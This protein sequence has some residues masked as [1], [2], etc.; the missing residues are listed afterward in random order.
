M[1]GRW[2][3][4]R[5]AARDDGDDLRAV[6]LDVEATGLDTRG[7]SLL[8]IAALALRVDWTTRRLSLVLGDSFS[9]RVR[10]EAERTDKANVLVHGI[11]VGRQREGLPLPQALQ[12]FSDF[13]GSAPALG[14]HVAYDE[15][16]LD[17][18]AKAQLGRALPL[19][20]LE[21]GH[22]CAAAFPEVRARSLDDWLA[23]FGITC[24]SRHEAMADVLAECELLQ[25]VW[26]RVA[27]E[28]RSWREVQRFAGRH[29]WLARR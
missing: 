21:I 16:L 4:A 2:W 27:R 26:P 17:R 18:H 23:H 6:V 19:R 5:K 14:F 28:C 25:R 15:A 1:S 24:L 22:L 13:A 9:V 3:P 20:W 12:A 29:A 8:A 11:G 10:H 7:A